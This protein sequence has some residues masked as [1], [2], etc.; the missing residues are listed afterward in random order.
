MTSGIVSARKE[1]DQAE[2]E[3]TAEGGCQR[4]YNAAGPLFSIYILFLPRPGGL[5]QTS[6]ESVLGQDDDES[7]AASGGM[8]IERRPSRQE[9]ESPV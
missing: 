8:P 9:K 6:D 4:G 7:K 3:W 2:C 1:E 5:L